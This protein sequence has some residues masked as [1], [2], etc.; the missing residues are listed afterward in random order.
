MIQFFKPKSVTKY[1][2][3]SLTICVYWH[4][5][6]YTFSTQCLSLNMKNM[7]DG[8]IYRHVSRSVN[9]TTFTSRIF[10][11]SIT[12]SWT[13]NDEGAIDYTN[14]SISTRLSMKATLHE[15]KLCCYLECRQLLYNFHK[16]HRSHNVSD[17]QVFVSCRSECKSSSQYTRCITGFIVRR[18]FAEKSNIYRY[19]IDKKGKQINKQKREKI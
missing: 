16:R 7:I 13:D 4:S 19:I 6:E 17:I 5:S 1:L 3:F 9:L 11:I 18:C 2:N 14:H 15:A 8:F 10:M 12:R